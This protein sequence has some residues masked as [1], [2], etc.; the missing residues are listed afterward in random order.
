[1]NLK[2]WMLCRKQEKIEI[3]QQW[4]KSGDYFA[5]GA[6]IYVHNGK[7]LLYTIASVESM[8]KTYLTLMFQDKP[9]F[10]LQG[11]EYFCPTCEKIVRSG[12]QLEQTDAF[13]IEAINKENTSFEEA[14]CEMEPLFGLLKDGYY[15]VWDT[16]LCPT[17]G[18]GNLFWDY[19]NDDKVKRG[20]C[21]YYR[22]NSEWA[23]CRPHYTIATQPC[24]K[25]SKERVEY[26]R[27]K[28]ECRA[29]AFYMDGNLTALID[30][31][32][33]AMAAALEH[34]EVRA[35]VISPCFYGYQVT[36]SGEKKTY[37]RANDVTIFSDACEMK[38]TSHVSEVLG[39]EQINSVL[40]K[41]SKEREHFDFGDFGINTRELAGFYPT[42]HEYA[43]I[44]ACG[45]ITETLIDDFMHGK[46]VF[47]TDICTFI[48][49]LAGL[50]H[51][52]L[53]EVLDYILYQ[54]KYEQNRIMLCALEQIVKLPRTEKIEE[55][56]IAYLTEKEGDF[57]GVGQF[58]LDNL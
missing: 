25:M 18:N 28:P 54:R 9:L 39:P 17:D 30:G 34:R 14:L 11:D 55:Y 42:V 10:Y 35:L 53:F 29:V 20:S 26:Y 5:D 27:K 4:K 52:R 45:E 1:M 44:D 7:G 15:C 21:V 6:L 33:K 16:M 31:H 38:S 2:N 36:A 47:D 57:P 19:P 50:K 48:E 32:H 51:E 58:I 41:M 24:F 37:M 56:L 40:S 49:A 46:H 43:S 8:E 23:T 22:G 3:K 13:H 12:Y